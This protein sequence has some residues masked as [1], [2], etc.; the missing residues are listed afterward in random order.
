MPV[1]T[2]ADN[3]VPTASDFNTNFRDQVVSTVTSATRPAGTAGQLIYE[4]DTTRYMGYNGGWVN[5]GLL[6]AWNTYA[7]SVVQSGVVTHTDS[8]ARYFKIG[9]LVSF[10]VVLDITGT[11]TANTAVSVSLPFTAAVSN[12]NMTI[13]SGH[14]RDV[15]AGLKYF[16]LAVQA[17]TTTVALLE[18]AQGTDRLLG[19]TGASFAAALASPDFISIQATY[20]ANA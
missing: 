4:T 12:T 17:S 5:F 19:A 3:D 10:I 15:S 14:I 6:A 9:R 20:E 11:G 13:G 8:Y 18:I 1:H 16:G 7:P 2:W